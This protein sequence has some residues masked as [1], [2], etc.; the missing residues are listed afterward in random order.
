MDKSM[1]RPTSRVVSTDGTSIAV[2]E[3]GS[4]PPLV[5]VHGAMS[6]HRN[7]AAFIAALGSSFRTY[8]V[9]RRGRGASADGD[10]YSIER[11]FDDIATVIDAIPGADEVAV[12]GHSYGAD[13]AMGAAAR[14]RRV[15]R[16]ILYEPGLGLTY[17]TGAV[18]AVIAAI[19]AGDSDA[20]AVALLSRVVEMSDA[21][22]AHVKG[23][24]TWTDRLAFVATIPRELMAESGWVYRTDQFATVTAQ[25]LLLDGSESPASQRAATARAAAALPNARLRVLDG[26]GHMAHRTDPEFVARIVCEFI[27][28]L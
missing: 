3:N 22:V 27:E 26:H 18:E 5:L 10:D 9:D 21:E 15:H 28:T 2:F 8:A 12:W 25:V 14:S 11:E 13:V 17:P 4:G 24:P 23:L 6:D 16:L 1:D 20:A 7:D 19:D